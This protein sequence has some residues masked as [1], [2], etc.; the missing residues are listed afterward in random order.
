MQTAALLHVVRIDYRSTDRLL[1]LEISFSTLVSHTIRRHNS[2]SV[3]KPA[4]VLF[5]PNCLRFMNVI[6]KVKGAAD[7]FPCWCE[8]TCVAD[9][10]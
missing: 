2:N 3:E 10:L 5:N 8:C 1:E 7:G 9:T 4:S 6:E